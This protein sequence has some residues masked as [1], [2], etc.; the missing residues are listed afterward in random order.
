[1]YWLDPFHYYIEG[2]AVNELEHLTVTC[3]E[4]DLVKFP[5]P[6]GQTCGEYT[7][8]FFSNPATPG[9]IAN[10]DAMQPEQC[11]YCTY[12]SG[13]QFYKSSFQWGERNKWTNVGILAGF[14]IFNVIVF[15]CLVYFKR[16]GRR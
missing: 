5:P 13:E 7:K 15:V 14:F 2:L 10:P 8:A 3:T 4:D 9:Y 11:G 6:P 12:S 1:M 16:K